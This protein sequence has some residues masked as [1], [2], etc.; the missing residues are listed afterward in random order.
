MNK[1]SGV[2]R[3]VVTNAM[4]PMRSRRVQL[5]IPSLFGG[6]GSG[7]AAACVPPGFSAGSDAYKVGDSV[8]VAFE[9]GDRD[10]PVVLGKLP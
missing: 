4:D 9:E 6:Q 5:Q 1:L 10:R 8:I 2:F 7:R 3:G